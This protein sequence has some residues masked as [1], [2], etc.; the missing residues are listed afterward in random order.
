MD[1]V[2][3]KMSDSLLSCGLQTAY[4][5]ISLVVAVGCSLLLIF[6]V[7]KK[8]YLQKPR[9]Y[10]RCNLAIDDLLFTGCMIP[11]KISA[12]F[13][14][15][16][17]SLQLSCGLQRIVAPP[18]SISMFGTYLLMAIELYYFIC[19]PL[20]Y[21]SKVTTKNVVIGIVAVRA[22][23][24]FFGVSPVVIKQLQNPGSHI[25]DTDPLSSTTAAAIFR[26]IYQ[27]GIILVVLAIIILYFFVFKEARKQQERDE[28]RNL[29]LCQTK[30]FKTLAPHIIVLAVSVITLISMLVLKRAMLT[31]D[32]A[33]ISMHRAEKAASILY[34]TLSSMVNPIIYSVRQPEFRQALRELCG[35]PPNA[36][37]APA[38]APPPIQHAQDQ[39][40]AVFSVPNHGE[41]SSGQEV[42]SATSS[43]K[44]VS[45]EEGQY[46]ESTGSSQSSPGIDNTG[47]DLWLA[48]TMSSSRSSPN[49]GNRRQAWPAIIN[50]QLSPNIGDTGRN[51]WLAGT[52]SS[53]QSRPNTGKGTWLAGI[54]SQVNPNTGNTGRDQQ[55]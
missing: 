36:P 32:N 25:C 34:L 24:L 44:E 53:Y 10:L 38:A 47:R 14:K 18:L 17:S 50:S 15:N 48:G 20:H 13:S 37:V 8:E 16:R 45:Q 4:L 3:R 28:N 42:T 11:M 55:L 39:D 21:N 19:H 2:Y 52:T 23:A 41:E 7:W 30:A 22:L 1:R 6:L 40:M 5:T 51:Q 54:T 26:D 27:I 46:G 29:W 35:M 9:H 43:Q 49:K 33:P 31:K 12:L